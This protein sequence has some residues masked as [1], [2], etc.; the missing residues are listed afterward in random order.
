MSFA[1][2]AS[3]QRAKNA[4]IPVSDGK[5]VNVVMGRNTSEVWLSDPRLLGFTLAKYKFVAKMLNIT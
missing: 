5:D 4:Y 2:K 1:G 3:S